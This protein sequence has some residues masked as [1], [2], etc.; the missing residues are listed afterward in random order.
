MMAKHM[1]DGIIEGLRQPPTGKREEEDDDK[2]STNEGKKYDEQ[3]VLMLQGFS[4]AEGVEDLQ[5]I[6]AA[7]QETKNQDAHRLELGTYM[8]EWAQKRNV[9][10]IRNME[11]SDKVMTAI[12]S[13]K[14]NPP[15]CT[16]AA[17]SPGVGRRSFAGGLG[18]L[19][20]ARLCWPATVG[21]AVGGLL[22]R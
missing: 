22:R 2:Q 3:Q 4:H 19:A 15:G 21:L 8:R 6:W 13:M 7:F 11:F 16:G 10:I 1:R 5:P 14:F 20:H 9:S 18:G 12:V 17:F